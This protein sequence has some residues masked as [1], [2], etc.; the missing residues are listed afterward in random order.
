MKYL[1][2]LVFAMVL[3]LPV[4]AAQLDRQQRWEIITA[5]H[6]LGRQWPH[7]YRH[8]QRAVGWRLTENI[9]KFLG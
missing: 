8:F 3:T 2:L 9:R 5:A 7:F 6:T 1:I 4:S